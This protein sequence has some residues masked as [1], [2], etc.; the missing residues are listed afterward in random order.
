MVV[1]F[2]EV[3]QEWNLVDVVLYRM[4]H[5]GAF[6][7]IV[8]GQRPVLEVKKRGRWANDKSLKRYAKGVRLQTTE[9]DAGQETLARART[10]LP[11]LPHLF[12]SKVFGFLRH[13]RQFMSR[14]LVQVRA[15]CLEPFRSWVCHAI[16]LTTNL[17]LSEMCS[18]G[19]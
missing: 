16:F 10:Y 12:A 7:D 8:N 13:A 2:R 6:H 18:A 4:R 19:A 15:G 1:M 11:H 14:D 3:M 5:G 17:D 9:L